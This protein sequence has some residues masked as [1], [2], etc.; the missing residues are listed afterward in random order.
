[1]ANLDQIPLLHWAVLQNTNFPIE[2]CDGEMLSNGSQG[3]KKWMHWSKQRQWTSA[4]GLKKGCQDLACCTG[5]NIW[6]FHL[7]E[8]LTKANI[9]ESMARSWPLLKEGHSQRAGRQVIVPSTLGR[10]APCPVLAMCSIGLLR[11]LSPPAAEWD[12]TWGAGQWPAH[13]PAA[14]TGA[15][16]WGC[17]TCWWVKGWP[18]F[19]GLGTRVSEWAPESLPS[20]F[21]L[22]PGR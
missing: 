22:A 5:T 3:R 7:L 21:A 6:V 17:G 2:N 4:P 19:G 9:L 11:C 14:G 18:T 8:T 16:R 1:M 12:K 20:R 10:S 13:T 15:G